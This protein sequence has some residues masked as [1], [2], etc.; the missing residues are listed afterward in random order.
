[1]KSRVLAWVL[2]SGSVWLIDRTRKQALSA[3]HTQ[4]WKGWQ[5]VIWIYFA[6]VL[7]CFISDLIIIVIGSWRS[8]LMLIYKLEL[9]SIF[10]LYLLFCSLFLKHPVSDLCFLPVWH[11]LDFSY[12]WNILVLWNWLLVG[13]NFSLWT[14]VTDGSSP[15]QASCQRTQTRIEARQTSY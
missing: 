15:K 9:L 11:S 13:I 2:Y 3:W 4:Q 7:Q 10:I 12:Y 6:S 5:T 8:N 14:L 1:M